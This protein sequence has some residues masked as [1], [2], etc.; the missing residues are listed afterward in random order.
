[1]SGTF[2]LKTPM[3]MDCFSRGLGRSTLT[4]FYTVQT[5]EK[6]GCE[7]SAAFFTPFAS[8]R[9]NSIALLPLITRILHNQGTP[10]ARDISA[11]ID[12][13][14]SQLADLRSAL[15]KQVSASSDEASRYVV[16]RARQ[17]AKHFQHGSSDLASVVRRNPQATTGAIVGA[18]ALTA[19]VAFILSRSSSDHS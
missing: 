11:E 5:V 19:A 4:R 14:T 12:R 8:G 1:M 6:E 15:A 9:R 13:L 3:M 16:P 10:M 18:L 2:S 7:R 17:V